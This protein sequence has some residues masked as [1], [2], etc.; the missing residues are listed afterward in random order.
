MKS[1]LGQKICECICI[2]APH[3]VLALF[4]GMKKDSIHMQNTC[5]KKNA[6]KWFNAIDFVDLPILILCLPLSPPLPLTHSDMVAFV[7]VINT[8]LDKVVK[9]PDSRVREVH[10]AIHSHRCIKIHIQVIT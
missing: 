1:Q 3:S 8:L 7:A 10:S 2:R 5:E 4:S 6:Q 9:T